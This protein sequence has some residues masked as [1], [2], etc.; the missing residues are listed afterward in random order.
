ML[1][2]FPV[3]LTKV[4]LKLTRKPVF[5]F[6]PDRQAI[7]RRRSASRAAIAV[8]RRTNLKGGKG[9]YISEKNAD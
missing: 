3:G 7:V 4:S 5:G 8:V 6:L 1:G 9:E 2:F